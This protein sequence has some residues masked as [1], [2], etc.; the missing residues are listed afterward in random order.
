[1]LK[2]KQ[3]KQKAIIWDLGNTLVKPNAFKVIRIY[4]KL[5]KKIG[6]KAFAISLYQYY[7]DPLYI[8]RVFHDALQMQNSCLYEPM[9]NFLT[10]TGER[11][12]LYKQAIDCID[13]SSNETIN[14]YKKVMLKNTVDLLFNSRQFAWCMSIIQSGLDLVKACY[15]KKD[16]QGNKLNNLFILSNWDTE[17]FNYLYN[18]EKNRELFKYFN[19]DQVI[20]SGKIG[21]LKP[22]KPVYEYITEKFNLRYQDCVFID[23]DARNVK[24]AKELGMIAFLADSKDYKNLEK[25]LKDIGVI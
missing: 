21:L 9:K 10:G 16:N 4:L 23:D 20:I 2:K 18:N 25:K 11:S 15:N 24:T 1:M 19:P 17:S 6:I 13:S 3:I 5:A 22:D 12:E 14:L 8:H 7:Q